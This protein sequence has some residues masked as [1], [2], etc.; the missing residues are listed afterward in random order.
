LSILRE[1]KPIALVVYS[2][3]GSARYAY[4]LA[5][6]LRRHCGGFLAVVPRYA[7]SAATILTLGANEILMNVHAELGPLDAQIYDPEHQVEEHRPSLDEVEAL[8]QL[9]AFA[10]Q[11]FLEIMP[12]L[13]E[14]SDLKT[15]SLMPVASDFAT[16]L[17]APLFDKIDVARYAEVSRALKL[18]E[19]YA[20]RLLDMNYG[21]DAERISRFLTR[22]YPEHGFPIYSEELR[23][24]GLRVATPVDPVQSILEEMTVVLRG[25]TLIGRVV[26]G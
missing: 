10:V 23:E 19:E 13:T 2:P 7:K 25:I 12:V 4:E 20:R 26:T 5:M 16:R 17:V 18:G 24:I 22:R 1:G 8:E 3:G 14:G 6:L 15:S 11:V 21:P 9:R